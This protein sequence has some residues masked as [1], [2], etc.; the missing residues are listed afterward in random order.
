MIR[1]LGCDVCAISRMQKILENPRFLDRW[2]TEYERGYIAA[3]KNQAQTVSGIFA[4]KEAFVKAIG[5]GLKTPL[6]SFSVVLDDTS[7]TLLQDIT[8][9]PIQITEFSEGDYRIAVVGIGEAVRFDF[10]R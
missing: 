1:G 5:T 6:N 8:P 9:L 2:F 3:R 7:A 10:I 4:A